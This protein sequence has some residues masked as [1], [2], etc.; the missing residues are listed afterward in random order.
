MRELLDV[1]VQSWLAARLWCHPFGLLVSSTLTVLPSESE[2]VAREVVV[3]GSAGDGVI[4]TTF[5]PI[6][7]DGLQRA[8]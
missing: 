2:H 6:D 7:T 1:G 8:L 4:D 3:R 5:V